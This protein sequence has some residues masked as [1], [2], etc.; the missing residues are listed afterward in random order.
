MYKQFDGTATGG[1]K[2]AAAVEHIKTRVS[3]S[4]NY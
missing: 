4:D 1:G 3:N 2:H